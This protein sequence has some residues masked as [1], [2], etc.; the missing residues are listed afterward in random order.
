MLGGV[1]DRYRLGCWF[2]APYTDD[3]AYEHDQTGYRNDSN[4]RN[5]SIG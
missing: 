3:E 5:T 4:D 2:A 1:F